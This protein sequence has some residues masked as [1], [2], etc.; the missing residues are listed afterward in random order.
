MN[1]ENVDVLQLTQ[2]VCQLINVQLRLKD[3]VYLVRSIS[4]DVPKFINSDTQRIK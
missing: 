4:N 1:I 3:S 2:E